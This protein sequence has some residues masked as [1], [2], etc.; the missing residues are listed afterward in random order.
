MCISLLPSFLFGKI[1]FIGTV[2]AGAALFQKAVNVT[3]TKIEVQ[4][5]HTTYE[6]LRVVCFK[7][8]GS[9]SFLFTQK[10]FV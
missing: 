8:T 4:D 3:H 1:Y 10:L 7:K 5:S 2:F 6:K 9:G